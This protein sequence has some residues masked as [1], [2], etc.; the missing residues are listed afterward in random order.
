MKTVTYWKSV[1]GIVMNYTT[2]ITYDQENYL[3]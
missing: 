1:K 2:L 3:K